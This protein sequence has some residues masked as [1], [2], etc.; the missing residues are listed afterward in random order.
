MNTAKPFY[1]HEPDSRIMMKKD[2]VEVSN[3]SDDLDYVN[4]ELEYLLDI[5]DS[6]LRNPELYRQLHTLRRDNQLVLGALY[7][8][9]SSM[10]NA[11]E[12]D[13]T[14]CD[15]YYLHKHEKHRTMYL[16]HIKGYRTVKA[17]VLS[18]ILLNTKH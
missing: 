3:W 4:Q 10:R 16:D 13:T 18:K 1:S 17:K 11:V 6:M 15:A 5:E 7:R 8:Y 2:K 14:Q 12:C 9:E